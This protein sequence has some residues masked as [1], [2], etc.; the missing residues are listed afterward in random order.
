MCFQQSSNL[1][2]EKLICYDVAGKHEYRQGERLARHRE[3]DRSELSLDVKVG[4]KQRPEETKT[5]PLFQRP[6]FMVLLFSKFIILSFCRT[7]PFSSN[8]LSSFSVH[9]KVCILLFLLLGWYYY[10]ISI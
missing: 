6:K 5:I 4:H 2:L 7:K 10:A 9:P 3:R 1:V 8:E